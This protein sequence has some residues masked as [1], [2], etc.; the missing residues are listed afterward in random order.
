MTF[1]QRAALAVGLAFVAVA[2]LG[3]A[4]SHSMDTG[5]VVGLFAVNAVHNGV[6]L[7]FGLWGLMAARTFDAAR[8][9]GLFGGAAYVA[10]A[11]VGRISPNGF[12]LVPIGGNDVCLHAAM[13]I[14]LLGL[15]L[16]ARPSAG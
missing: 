3:L 14:A 2:I 6:H 4:S 13:G 11:V 5:L 8:R 16:V 15:G 7:L 1:I 9:Y 10:L 12:G